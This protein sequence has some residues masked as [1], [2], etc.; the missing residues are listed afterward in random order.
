[1]DAVNGLVRE[2]T[3]MSR[4][5]RSCLNSSISLPR[6]RRQLPRARISPDLEPSF[7]LPLGAFGT[8]LFELAC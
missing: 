4:Q 6:L 5:R 8:N 1:M 2:K 3:K 7:D